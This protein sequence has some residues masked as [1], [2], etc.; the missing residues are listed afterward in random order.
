MD[1]ASHVLFVGA[2]ASGKGLLVPGLVQIFHL[3]SF[4][5]FFFL[6]FPLI[7]L[8]WNWCCLFPDIIRAAYKVD[9]AVGTGTD[10]VDV[11]AGSD[12]F[13]A[14][15]KMGRWSDAFRCHS[16]RHSEKSVCILR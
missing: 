8:D 3:F 11:E 2:L 6:C 14:P 15:G 10:Q 16:S 7:R 5:F 1:M 13:E 9:I 12:S 4:S